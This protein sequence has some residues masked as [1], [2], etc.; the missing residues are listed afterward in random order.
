MIVG[1]FFFFIGISVLPAL[2]LGRTADVLIGVHIN[3][4]ESRYWWDP[5]PTYRS[6]LIT[7]GAG[8]VEVIYAS[9]GGSIPFPNPL[10]PEDYPV[11][12]VLT[13]ENWLKPP[14][15]FGPAEEAILSDYC[16]AGGAVMIVGQDLLY[17]AHGGWGPAT[18]FFENYMGL[19]YVDQDILTTSDS[20]VWV[21]EQGSPLD[22]M[23]GTTSSGDPWP[24]F[25][26]NK[27]QA[28]DLTPVAG[29]GILINCTAG[30]SG[31]YGTGIYY[32]RAEGR[33]LNR[34]CFVAYEL[35]ADPDSFNS[36]ILA[37]YGWLSTG[38]TGI[39]PVS[40]GKLKAV[41]R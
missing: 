18:G 14:G 25:L 32:N 22:D 17:G 23:D 19:S 24:P 13:S 7:A 10:L 38:E 27:C 37:L 41:Y 34:S 9:E 6:A 36:V 16:E 26:A 1:A 8:T 3:G 15:N 20:V 33:T 5:G 29:A 30:S 4:E 28:D 2:S 35:A 40:L 11:C 21:G 39:E 12:I 31:P